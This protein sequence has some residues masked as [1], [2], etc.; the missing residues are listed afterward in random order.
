MSGADF[1]W[2]AM[3]SKDFEY[4]NWCTQCIEGVPSC[5]NLEP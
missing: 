1:D 4:I 5:D 2:D 3:I